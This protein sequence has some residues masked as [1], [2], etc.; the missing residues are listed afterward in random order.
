MIGALVD[1]DAAALVVRSERSGVAEASGER[2][3]VGMDRIT[4]RLDAAVPAGRLAEPIGFIRN[5]A[6]A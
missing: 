4:V 6:S 5:L 2:L 3:E 1:A